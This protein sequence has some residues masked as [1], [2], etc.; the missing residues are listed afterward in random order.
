M[1]DPAHAG[2]APVRLLGGRDEVFYADTGLAKHTCQ[3]ANLE[4]SMHGDD[5]ARRDFGADE[6]AEIP[7][8]RAPESPLLL[9]VVGA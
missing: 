3:S 7:I 4:L 5:A 1:S 6:P 8:F 9:R 2:F